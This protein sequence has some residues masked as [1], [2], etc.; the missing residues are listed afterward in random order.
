MKLNKLTERLLAEG[1]TQDQT[2]PL[3]RPWRSFDGGW[4]YDFRATKD[5]VFET[6][7]G[8]L[9]ER[10]EV[11]HSGSMYFGGIEW[12]LEND[13]A[14][15]ICPYYDK[16]GPCEK[17]HPLLRNHGAAGCQQEKL[18]FCAVQ[19]SNSAYTYGRSVQAVRDQQEAEQERLWRKFQE[20]H[21]GRVCKLQCRYNRRTKTWRKQ[22]DPWDCA[23]IG[24]ACHHCS[25]LEEDLSQIKGNVFYDVVTT[26]IRA[27][28]GLFEDEQITTV[29]RGKRLLER[30]VS[31]TI[32]EA[33][34]RYSV[35]RV[36]RHLLLNRHWDLFANPTLR[37]EYCN[38]RAG[39]AAG[40][41]L[42]QDM[43]DAANGI[44]VSHDADNI[45]DAKRVK[46]EKR[47]AAAKKKLAQM[48]R[49]IMSDGL[50]NIPRHLMV[51]MERD[52]GYERMK[53][54]DEM[55]TKSHEDM[56]TSLF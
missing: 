28:E 39:K 24:G 37:I 32:C 56:Q 26:Y 21:K 35:W 52:L 1:W 18:F 34:C 55:R 25:V 46:R 43:Q 51:R 4:T 36:K 49:R 7:C 5:W 15:I 29:V 44:A 23:K 30:N 10:S 16:A 41:D 20:K 48:E 53:E 33:I 13:A 19:R 47:E 11:H 45:A 9:M 6:P 27:G 14:T 3:C 22:Y 8:L 40:R 12:C 54:L 31:L 42:L 38:F 17:N 2:P 50:E